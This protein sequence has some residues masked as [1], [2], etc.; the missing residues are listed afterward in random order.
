MTDMF[1]DIPS[2]DLKKLVRTNL[3]WD[4]LAHED[5]GEMMERLGM[6]RPSYE[7]ERVACADSHRR[8]DVV[9]SLES[10]FAYMAAEI[11][12][13]VAEVI[14]GDVAKQLGEQFVDQWTTQTAVLLDAG[15]RVMVANLIAAEIL[16]FRTKG[17]T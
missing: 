9:K 16:T 2:E 5:A 3:I 14:L 11:A 10:D 6:V 13:I 7:G 8:M 4:L 17:K 15:S 1:E 12:K